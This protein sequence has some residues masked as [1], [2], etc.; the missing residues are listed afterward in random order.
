MTD[1]A[2]IERLL[3]M[4]GRTLEGLPKHFSANARLNFVAKMEIGESIVDRILHQSDV[5][6]L[7]IGALKDALEKPMQK[8][9]TLEEL[10]TEPCDSYVWEE[11]RTDLNIYFERTSALVLAFVCVNS[12]EDMYKYG[13]S[14]RAW[15]KMP[16]D[17]ER[18]AAAWES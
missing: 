17:E 16:T 3:Q 10:K 5:I 4:T 11:R 18:E 2:E 1:R 6:E 15:K 14:V 8:P 7:L 12:K 9:L 13:S